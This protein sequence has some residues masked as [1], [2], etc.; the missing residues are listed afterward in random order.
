MRPGPLEIIIVILVIVAIALITRIIRTG[1]GTVRE[2]KESSVTM[3]GKPVEEK[4]DRI[5]R[6]LARSGVVFLLVGGMLLFTG[7]T[8][9]RW[10]FQSYSWAFVLMAIGFALIL[11]FRKK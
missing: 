11:L 1:Q 9:F 10:A 2:N 8:M 7:I 6:F 5:R 3:L 4:K